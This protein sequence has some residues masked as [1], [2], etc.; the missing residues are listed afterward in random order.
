VEHYK[1]LENMYLD[2]NCN[3]IYGPRIKINEG[4]CEISIDVKEEFFHA[5]GAVH[6]SVYFKLLDDCAFFAANSLEKDN[7]VLTTSFTTYITKPV[8][9]GKMIGIGKVVSRT[10]KTFISESI[11]L[12]V[13]GNEVARG[14]GIFAI[15]ASDLNTIKSYKL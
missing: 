4:M 9:D 14:S 15:S 2:A 6:G 3:K 5:A 1:K 7:F 11:I 10:K 8:V 13:K 12:D